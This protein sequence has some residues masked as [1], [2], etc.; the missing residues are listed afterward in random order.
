MCLLVVSK[1]LIP[2]LLAFAVEGVFL[3]IFLEVFNGA[4]V[5]HFD[6]PGLLLEIFLSFSG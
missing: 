1:P 4:V 3:P 5:Q 6:Q 2:R